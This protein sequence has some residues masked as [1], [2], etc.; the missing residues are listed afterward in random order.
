[1]YYV[2]TGILSHILDPARNGQE[3]ASLAD[4]IGQDCSI[5]AAVITLCDSSESLLASRVPDLQLNKT[6]HTVRHWLAS[7][8]ESKDRT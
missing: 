3:R 4:I 7:F 6:K 8:P 1:M 5:G 2:G